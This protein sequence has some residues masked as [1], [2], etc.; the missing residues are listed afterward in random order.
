MLSFI[1]EQSCM[2]LHFNIFSTKDVHFQSTWKLLMYLVCVG[3][4]MREMKVNVLLK[5]LA[6]NEGL[7]PST[8]RLKV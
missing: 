2:D 6:P 1:L 4:C 8:L 3:R 7:E 5:N